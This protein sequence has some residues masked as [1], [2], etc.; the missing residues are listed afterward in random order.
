MQQVISPVLSLVLEFIHLI[1]N[2][3]QPVMLLSK[4]ALG[5]LP[6][7]RELPWIFYWIVRDK[8]LLCACLT[9]LPHYY[10]LPFHTL[11]SSFGSHN[12]VSKR[13]RRIFLLPFSIDPILRHLT[14]PNQSSHLCPFLPLLFEKIGTWVWTEGTG[15]FYFSSVWFALSLFCVSVLGYQKCSK[16]F[17]SRFLYLCNLSYSRIKDVSFIR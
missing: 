1:M 4:W 16:Y 15:F 3:V 12:L 5:L 10:Y 7:S 6:P 9:S 11:T 17:F 14:H 2:L 8:K 13:E